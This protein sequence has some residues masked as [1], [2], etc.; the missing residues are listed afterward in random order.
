MNIVEVAK[1]RFTSK[2][3][4]SEKKLTPE[5]HQ[6]LLDLLR[7]SPSSLNLQP[8]HFFA[9]TS[10]EGKAQILPGIREFNAAKVQNAAMVVVFTTVNQL[11]DQHLAAVH[12][13]ET[14]DG[15]FKDQA[16][17][18]AQD[19]GRRQYIEAFTGDDESKRHWLEHQ[20]Y[21]SLGFLLLGAAAM[22]L[23]ATPIEGF[24]PEKMD[25]VLGLKE[26]GLHSLVVA[27]V[28]F[29]S[30]EKDFNAQLPKS[31]FSEQDVITNL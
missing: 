2:A 29:N 12:A 6:Q 26:K 1:Q 4:D 19:K 10:D 27:S 28:G 25:E 23:H 24:D 13:Q 11:D 22:G 18:D 14:K 16:S 3:Y 20:A 9:V 15:R 31:R 17:A 5:Q 21:I 30:E 7:Y 8:W